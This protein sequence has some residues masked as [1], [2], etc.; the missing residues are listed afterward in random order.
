MK[1]RSGSTF[2]L[3]TPSINLLPDSTSVKVDSKCETDGDFLKVHKSFLK[4]KT[5]IDLNEKLVISCFTHKVSLQ[6]NINL[7]S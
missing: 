2:I 1:K 7:F 6:S 5:N 3:G 4:A